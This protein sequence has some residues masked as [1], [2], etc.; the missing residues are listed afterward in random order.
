M[1]KI[2]TI[3]KKKLSNGIMIILKLDLKLSIK[4]IKED[5]NNQLLNKCFK[6]YQ[7]LLQK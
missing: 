4:Q 1:L 6:D 2:F 7:Q 3:H 5:L